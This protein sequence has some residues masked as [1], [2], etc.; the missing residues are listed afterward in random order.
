MKNNDTLNT[1]GQKN[2]VD[3]HNLSSVSLCVVGR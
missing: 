2:T 3:T 1:K